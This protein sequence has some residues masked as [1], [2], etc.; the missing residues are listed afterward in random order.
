MSDTRVPS[1][2]HP[3]AHAKW[4]HRALMQDSNL[5]HSKPMRGA[6]GIIE[7]NIAHAQ[8]PVKVPRCLSARQYL[9][10]LVGSD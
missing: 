10:L 5:A 6:C 2:P 8:A 1:C 3:D 4:E 9:D 7:V